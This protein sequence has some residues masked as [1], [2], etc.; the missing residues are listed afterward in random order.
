ME[1]RACCTCLPD[2]NF[3]AL[4]DA[5]GMLLFAA[6]NRSTG[7]PSRFAQ[8]CHQRRRGGNGTARL[9]WG[10]SS[11]GTWLLATLSTLESLVNGASGDLQVAQCLLGARQDLLWAPMQMAMCGRNVMIVH[12]KADAQE[13]G[14]PLLRECAVQAHAGCSKYAAKRHA[15][16]YVSARPYAGTLQRN[17]NRTRCSRRL[18]GPCA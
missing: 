17:I 7:S 12:W 11:Q 15:A 5:P 10:T 1:L 18:R 13:S 8:S 4:M 2:D 3:I 14:T 6:S 16:A 9:G